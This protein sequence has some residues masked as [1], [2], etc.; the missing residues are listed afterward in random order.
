MR[1]TYSNTRHPKLV[2][3]SVIA[4]V[5][6]AVA[7]FVLYV[8]FDEESWARSFFHIGWFV[9]FYSS[10]MGGSYL[11][12]KYTIDEEEDTIIFSERKKYPMKISNLTTITYKESKKGKFRS[13]LIHDSG[14]GFMDIRTSKDNADLIV[15]QL[16]KT[17]PSIVVKH[18]SYI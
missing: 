18:A 11:L 13:L 17:N 15:A 9:F 10:L 3:Y 2:K 6:L 5:L 12:L 16:T 4:G 7:C 14:V 1:T 8:I